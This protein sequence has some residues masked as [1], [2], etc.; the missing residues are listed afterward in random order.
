MV[1][2]HQHSREVLSVFYLLPGTEDTLYKRGAY[3]PTCNPEANVSTF[4]DC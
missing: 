3:T 2:A 1:Y 4:E